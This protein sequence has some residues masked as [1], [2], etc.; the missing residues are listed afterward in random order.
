MI[1]Q[2]LCMS[3][4][5]AH[6]DKPRSP[7]AHDLRK[8]CIHFVLS[9]SSVIHLLAFNTLR[10]PR[11]L[12]QF[13]IQVLVSSVTPNAAASYDSTPNHP[14]RNTRIL[15]CFLRIWTLSYL[16]FNGVIYSVYYCV[17]AIGVWK[18]RNWAATR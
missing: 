13:Y 14:A 10:S 2:G 5:I 1:F 15:C 7:S 12:S 17:F 6:D 18:F 3:L 4:Y 8:A 11:R 16:I 9:L